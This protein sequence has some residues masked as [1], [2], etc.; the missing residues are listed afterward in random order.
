MAIRARVSNKKE[1]R[2]KAV[3]VQ[4]PSSFAD[5]EDVDMNGAVTGGI[6]QF[7]ATTGKFKVA[8]QIESDNLIITGGSF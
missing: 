5:L 8:T 7:D 1:V 4:P 6:L 2:V 3:S